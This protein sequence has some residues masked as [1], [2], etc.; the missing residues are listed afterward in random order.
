MVHGVSVKQYQNQ[1]GR[2][3]GGYL[4]GWLMWRVPDATQRCSE[5]NITD[6]PAALATPWDG[7]REALS[8]GADVCELQQAA[9]DSETLQAAPQQ[10][11]LGRRSGQHAARQPEAG[12]TLA[13]HKRSYCMK[14]SEAPHVMQPS[15]REAQFAIAGKAFP[16]P[17][18]YVDVMEANYGPTWRLP[19]PGFHGNRVPKG[20]EPRLRGAL[21]EKLSPTAWGDMP[22]QER[23]EACGLKKLDT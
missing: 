11:L 17:F 5:A 14:E 4:D 20:D 8:A 2:L 9:P 1:T 6:L 19:E 10:T 15:L 13:A 3:M 22:W 18:N 21:L 7:D 16:I 12:D 23:K